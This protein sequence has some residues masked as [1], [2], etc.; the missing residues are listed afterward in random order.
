M[1]KGGENNVLLE[2]KQQIAQDLHSRFERARVVILTDYKGLNVGAMTE[3]RRRLKEA[4]IDYRVVKN[5]LLE[6]ASVDTPAAQ[7]REAFTGPSA[8]A[9]SYDD[10]V[11][12]AKVLTQFAKEN[13]KLKIRVG[14]LNGKAIGEADI[15]NLASRP[16]R[17]CSRSCSGSSTRCPPHWCGCLPPC[18]VV[19]STYST[20]SRKRNKPP[21]DPYRR[22]R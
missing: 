4:G 15:K 13:D 21:E 9:L 6:R 5:T 22:L 16:V 20:R 14:V 11:A 1:R 8:I 10:P 18:R 19:W 7:I 2:R 17:C 3:L 12:P